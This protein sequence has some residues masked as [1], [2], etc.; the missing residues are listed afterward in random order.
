MDESSV[1]EQSLK[2]DLGFTEGLSS[3]NAILEFLNTLDFKPRFESM[4]LNEVL[5]KGYVRSG[6]IQIMKDFSVE[7]RTLLVD[8]WLRCKETAAS[9]KDPEARHFAFMVEYLVFAIVK[10]NG[11]LLVMDTKELND[12]KAK[13]GREP[14]F[15]EQARHV[16]M[17]VMPPFMVEVLW[18]IA[19]KFKQDFEEVFIRKIIEGFKKVIEER[20]AL[21]RA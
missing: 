21:L 20:N 6:D 18:M 5:L 1:K 8:E 19:W 17:N 4:N 10:L 11:S 13:F 15:E 9:Y 7:V 12:F 14:T 2:N 3:L 16:L